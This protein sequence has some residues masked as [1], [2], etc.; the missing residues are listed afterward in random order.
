MGTPTI[1]FYP[2]LQKTRKDSGE[3]PLYL[4]IIINGS[5]SEAKLPIYLNERQANSWI[6]EYRDPNSDINLELSL[7]RKR[8][9]DYITLNSCSITKL[10]L[11]EIRDYVLN[12]KVLEDTISVKQF[13][14]NFYTN[15]VLPSND[16]TSG[17]KKN[18][19]KAYTHFYKF[20]QFHD[21]T[22]LV[23]ADVK[24]NLGASFKEYL[25]SDYPKIGKTSV[26]KETASGLIKKI[27]T[28]FEKAI[29]DELITINPFKGLKI[30]L[31]HKQKEKLNIYQ[32]KKLKELDLSKTPSLDK[33]RS[34]FL[35]QCF[36]GVAYVDLVS[37]TY[38][39]IKPSI[40]STIELNYVRRK[41]GCPSTQLVNVELAKLITLF[42]ENK[43]CIINRTLVPKISLKEL[44]L[45]LKVIAEKAEIPIRLSSHYGRHGFR[46]LLKE[47]RITEQSTLNAIMGWSIKNNNEMN[48]IYSDKTHQEFYEIKVQLDQYLNQHL[49]KNNDK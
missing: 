45:N 14:S 7:Y 34:L 37:L 49:S 36:S 41:T 2:N 6:N 4:R 23:F 26:T 5:K 32:I 15:S 28:A 27:A 43:S 44:N 47:A 33:C 21:L 12:K 42:K 20:L 46:Q 9:K 38:D 31:Q 10:K 48:S 40:K 30:K 18:Y 19:R 17:T 35:F 29:M 8:F 3:T 1:K 13:I 24:R 22:D 25:I 16:K 39:S 11:N